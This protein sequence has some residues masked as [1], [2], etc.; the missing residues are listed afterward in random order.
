MTIY[1]DFKEALGS[2]EANLRDN[3]DKV[4]NTT[5]LVGLNYTVIYPRLED[6]SPHQPWANIEF[7]DR[8][9]F[10][11]RNPGNSWKELPDVWEPMMEESKSPGNIKAF[12]YTYAERMA[13]HLGEVLAELRRDSTSRQAY[14]AIWNP[15]VDVFRLGYRRVPCTLGYQFFIR[16]N[17]LQLHYLQRSSN[18]LRHFQ[19]DLYLALK[20]QHWVA[21]QVGIKP[22]SFSH[23]IGSLH[24]FTGGGYKHEQ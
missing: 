22:S 12:S 7:E 6:L 2:I 23:W 20:L 1:K 18:F 3:G 11:P 13:Y 9:S 17:F 24:I 10:E 8:I 14:L 16:D 15:A 21:D 5:E 4:G 19:D